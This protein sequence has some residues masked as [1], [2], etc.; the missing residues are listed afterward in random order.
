MGCHAFRRYRNAWLKKQRVQE[1][2]RLHW[3]SHKPKEMGEIYSALKEDVSARLAEAERVSHGFSLPVEVVPN[4]P[5]KSHRKPSRKAV[6][7]GILVNRTKETRG[8]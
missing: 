2:R 6:A 3:M 7:S 8:V 4:V 1:D 5:K